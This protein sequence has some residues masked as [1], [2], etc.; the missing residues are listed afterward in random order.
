MEKK[1]SVKGIKKMLINEMYIFI[2]YDRRDNKY[3]L[4]EWDNDFEYE[5]V[6]QEISE[7]EWDTIREEYP[8]IDI[9]KE[10]CLGNKKWGFYWK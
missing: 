8:L 7:E 5:K 10:R 4:V 1:I 9:R 3:Y 6:I 2:R